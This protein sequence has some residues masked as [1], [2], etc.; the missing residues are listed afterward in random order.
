MLGYTKGYQSKK[1]PIFLKS[2]YNA[3]SSRRIG[4]L[5][6]RRQELK[7]RVST[8][9]EDHGC[10]LALNVLKGKCL[11]AAGQSYLLFLSYNVSW[12]SI[13]TDIICRI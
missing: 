1:S 2:Q 8:S 6:H 13:Q 4:A 5:G 12:G 3:A 11:K 10:T 9:Q 7:T